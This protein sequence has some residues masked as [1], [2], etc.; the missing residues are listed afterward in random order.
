MPDEN[1]VDF[2]EFS[3]TPTENFESEE[4]R[5]HYEKGLTYTVRESYSVL[6]ELFPKWLEQG[7]V[8]LIDANKPVGLINGEGE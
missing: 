8:E 6:R 5:S 4:L 1:V 2:E 7:K 3:F